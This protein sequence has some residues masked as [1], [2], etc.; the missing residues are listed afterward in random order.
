MNTFQRLVIFSVILVLLLS[1]SI[2]ASVFANTGSFTIDS[3][4]LY[5][6]DTMGIPTLGEISQEV[7][8]L[9]TTATASE[10][11]CYLNEAINPSAGNFEQAR[12]IA[13]NATHLFTVG[14]DQGA[15]GVQWRI[16]KRESKTGNLSLGFGDNGRGEINVDPSA[17]DDIPYAIAI[18]NDWMYVVGADNSPKP[19]AGRDSDWQWRIEKRSLLDGQKAKGFG[20]NADGVVVSNPSPSNDEPLAVA[21]FGDYLYVAGF[22]SSRGFN[23]FQ[24]RIEKRKLSDGTLAQGFGQNGVITMDATLYWDIVRGIAVDA[25][26]VYIAGVEGFDPNGMGDS[27]WRIEKR[28]VKDGSRTVGFG[29]NKDGIV[30]SNPSKRV[31]APRAIAI[32]TKFMYVVGFD[33]GTLN[34]PTHGQWRIEK[35]ALADGKL[36]PGF[37]NVG[38]GVIKSDPGDQDDAA[39]AIAIDSDYMYVAGWDV[40][41]K[42]DFYAKWR[43]E[44]RRLSDGT[45][46]PN[47]GNGGVIR[48]S[49]SPLNDIA[50][51]IT[52]SGN[53]FYAAGFDSGGNARPPQHDTQWRI[54]GNDK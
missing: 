12:G 53:C 13:A 49:F 38:P 44:K 9:S 6:A 35:R 31:D 34:L 14:D 50:N 10:N 40:I 48:A 36:D 3:S 8:Q 1:Q 42:N 27:A 45:F 52:V 21:I 29:D 47:F 25:D 18:D 16:E 37:G 22:D 30:I 19:N 41:A 28:N 39:Y 24:W 33:R 26:A 43:I 54:I 23:N 20:P 4:L 46:D 32:D 15:H 2:S 7:P 17:G 11:P 5:T 51:A